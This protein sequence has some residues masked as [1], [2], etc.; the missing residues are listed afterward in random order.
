MNV[1]TIST[2]SSI[3]MHTLFGSILRLLIL[4]AAS[5]AHHISSTPPRVAEEASTHLLLQQDVQEVAFRNIAAVE[6]LHGCRRLN[7][8][9]M[10]AVASTKVCPTFR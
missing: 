8:L 3:A 5:T 10:L 9:A 2:R 4:V 1:G 7:R 6:A